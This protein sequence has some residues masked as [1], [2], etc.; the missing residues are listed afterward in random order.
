[1]IITLNTDLRDMKH[2]FDKT[3]TNLVLRLKKKIKQIAFY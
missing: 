3:S 1:M 2:N